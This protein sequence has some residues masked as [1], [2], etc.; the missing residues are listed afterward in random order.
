MTESKSPAFLRGMLLKFG[1][2]NRKTLFSLMK[3]TLCQSGVYKH[4]TR[5]TDTG[6]I[7]HLHRYYQVSSKLIAH[8]VGR[9]N[10]LPIYLNHRTSELKHR[11]L[12]VETFVHLC[13]RSFISG[14]TMEYELEALKLQTPI[15]GRKPDG[16]VQVTRPDIGKFEIAIEVERSVKGPKRVSEVLDNY[17]T[18]FDKHSSLPLGLIVQAVHPVAFE[19]Y[20]R[21]LEQRPKTFRERVFLSSQPDLSDVPESKLGKTL[22]HP[23][24]NPFQVW[25]TYRKNSTGIDLYAPYFDLQYRYRDSGQPNQERFK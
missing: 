20:K 6:D 18:S 8:A 14:F 1:L 22:L 24:E 3:G 7:V 25:S 5:L 23:L 16:L 4:M 19:E 2:L 9:N 17:R 10:S 15:I 21:D 11:D 13:R 12:C